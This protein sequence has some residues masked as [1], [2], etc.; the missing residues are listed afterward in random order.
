MRWQQQ[1]LTLRVYY[2]IRLYYYIVLVPYNTILTYSAFMLSPFASTITQQKK[3]GKKKYV[4]KA[5]CL[6]KA[7]QDGATKE[8]M[9]LL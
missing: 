1:P 2:K 4:F 7:L 8:L 5:S 6:E 9:L 3:K